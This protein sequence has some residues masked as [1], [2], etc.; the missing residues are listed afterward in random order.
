MH[1]SDRKR[2]LKQHFIVTEPTDLNKFR[3]RRRQDTARGKTLCG[4][5][6]H[7]WEFDPHKQFDVK[8]G[9]LISIQ[10]CSRCGATREHKQ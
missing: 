10:R 3:K 9:R 7:K 6:F 8:Q 4:R 1:R 5:G 2:R